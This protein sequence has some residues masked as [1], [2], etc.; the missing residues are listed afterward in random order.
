[1]AYQPQWMPM[2]CCG[3]S[4]MER[5]NWKVSCW[6][7][8]FLPEFLTD[9]RRGLSRYEALKLRI[10]DEVRDRQYQNPLGALIRLSAAGLNKDGADDLDDDHE[11]A[12]MANGDVSHQRT[13]EALRSGVPNRD[14]VKVLGS[15]QPDLEGKF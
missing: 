6:W 4:L 10:W 2:K 5:M 12:A 11:Q 14:V 1:M 3:S 8:L 13:M 9:T 7:Y 15:H